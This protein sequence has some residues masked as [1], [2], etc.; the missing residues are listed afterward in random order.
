MLTRSRFHFDWSVYKHGSGAH[1]LRLEVGDEILGAMRIEH[2]PKEYRV[3]VELIAS[4]KENTGRN[5]VYDR[6]PGCLLAFACYA[7]YRLHG[8]E[9]MVSL[10]PKTALRGH[11]VK[12]YG[13]K[14][15][16]FRLA[17]EEG[18]LIEMI[19]QYLFKYGETA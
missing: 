16:G 1:V 8:D 2:F 13:M 9:A 10:L 14:A 15:K 17:L 3:E 19:N 5:K 12:K 4:S 18:D 6:I 11:Y 7:C